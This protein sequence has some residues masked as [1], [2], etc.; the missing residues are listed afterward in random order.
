MTLNT[1]ENGWK[2]AVSDII[3]RLVGEE[4]DSFDFESLGIDEWSYKIDGPQPP[5]RAYA[6]TTLVIKELV[7]M[8][9]LN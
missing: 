4:S 3:K 1:E 8:Y 7:K 2:E 5:D 9:C 6:L